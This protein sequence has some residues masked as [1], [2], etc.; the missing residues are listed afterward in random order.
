M[1]PQLLDQLK[2]EYNTLLEQG[3]LFDALPLIRQAAH[4]AD[5]DSQVLAERIYFHN[6]Y[7]HPRKDTAAYEYAMLAAMNGDP[8]S[9]YDLSW[10]Y[11]FGHGT[12]HDP[13]KAVY[14]LQKAADA[15]V[16]EA[17]DDL[18]LCYLQARGVERDVQK[19][20]QLFKKAIE[21][22]LDQPASKHLSMAEKMIEK[23]NIQ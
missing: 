1:D 9:M 8:A 14:W 2:A 10:L 5:F 22:G 13:K 19:A 18:G 23:G 7:H 17:L 4:W 11:R 12:V 16:P 6:A 21:Q 20:S 3:K 15:G